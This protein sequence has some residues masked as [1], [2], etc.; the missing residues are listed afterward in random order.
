MSFYET[1]YNKSWIFRAKVNSDELY[2]SAAEIFNKAD[3]T[4]NRKFSR[5]IYSAFVMG[6]N[7]SLEDIKIWMNRSLRLFISL[8]KRKLL[9]SKYLNINKING[10]FGSLEASFE[11][12]E[13]KGLIRILEEFY[14][15]DKMK[16]VG[17]D[18]VY[19]TPHTIIKI[20]K[21][22]EEAIRSGMIG[23]TW[24]ISAV[25]WG[26]TFDECKQFGDIY[27]I[28]TIPE[29]HKY[30]LQF[31]SLQFVDGDNKPVHIQDNQLSRDI[32]KFLKHN[33]LPSSGS[34]RSIFAK[35][36]YNSNTNDHITKLISS[37]F[38]LNNTTDV[39]HIVVHLYI[40]EGILIYYDNWELSHVLKACLDRGIGG[41]TDF[42]KYIR[43]FDHFK[44]LLDKCEVDV[45]T[46]CKDVKE[47]RP[48]HFVAS[49]EFW[50][51]ID[52]ASIVYM[53]PHYLVE[54]KDLK[55][56]H[57]DKIVIACGYKKCED[58]L[59]ANFSIIHHGCV[60]EYRIRLAKT[61]KTL[62]FVLFVNGLEFN[63]KTCDQFV[64]DDFQYINWD[65][66]WEERNQLIDRNFYNGYAIYYHVR[67]GTIKEFVN[68][69]MLRGGFDHFIKNRGI[70]ELLAT[71]L[72]RRFIHKRL[73]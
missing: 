59:S 9:P 58:F 3:P 60:R 19:Q 55:Q 29:G 30:L 11:S 45:D 22:K 2:E 26:N 65:K 68:K 39:A 33:N 4:S 10:L 1:Y 31:E 73:L 18:I 62:P 27:Y 12:D 15:V 67:K 42:I 25:P 50:K 20:L 36:E 7:R 69:H 52:Y 57:I 47:I 13:R 46:L 49:P 21:T 17:P 37:A 63:Y 35:K 32:V 54:S 72:K 43:R 61:F 66:E 40:T 48:P 51:F 41:Y 38:H 28:E 53:T 71:G 5:W 44:F 23:T 64:G 16:L 34:I 56:S 6:Y 70:E 8:T 14:K 24:S